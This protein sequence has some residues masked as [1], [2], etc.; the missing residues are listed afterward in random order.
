MTPGGSIIDTVITWLDEAIAASNGPAIFSS[1][2]LSYE[3]CRKLAVA[4][5]SSPQQF[6]LLTSLDPSAVANGYWSVE[7]V[8][9]LLGSGVEVRH[10]ERLHAKCFIVGDR[11]VIGSANLTGAG[12]GVS[13]KANK[14]IGV[15]LN[16][17][18]V[19]EARA[20]MDSWPSRPVSDSDLLRLLELAGELGRSREGQKDVLDADSALQLAEGLLA[21]ARDGRSLWLKLEYGDP[22]LDGWRSAS[23]FAS[24]KKGRPGFRPGDLV[25]I[26]AKK[27]SDG[28]AVVEIVGDPEYQP[29]AYELWTAANDPE[30]LDRWPW[31]SSTKPRLVPEDLLDLKLGE[32][33]VRAQALQNGH[34]RLKLD[35]FSAGVRSLA[36]LATT[37]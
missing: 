13:A 3:I 36:R 1:P 10:I 20:L 6:V 15:S 35:Q 8:R 34:V 4:A 31:I 7:G 23:W 5:D 22:A 11:G 9:A 18:Q 17:E 29:A 27:T 33:G 14:E 30:A 2:F 32:L 26:C 37:G 28:Y 21:D 19:R 16:G 25:I 12:M 24:P